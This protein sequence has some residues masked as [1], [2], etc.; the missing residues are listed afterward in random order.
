MHIWGGARVLAPECILLFIILYIIFP[1]LCKVCVCMHACMHVHIG[2]YQGAY[3]WGGSLRPNARR[4]CE[5]RCCN[6]KSDSIHLIHYNALVWWIIMIDTIIISEAPEGVGDRGA[7]EG[8]GSRETELANI[9]VHPSHRSES[10]IR[11]IDPSHRSE[12][13]IAKSSPSLIAKLHAVILLFY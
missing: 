7:S 1:V 6:G 9:R 2:S 10:P 12:S 4:R 8:D 3:I 5:T 11:V 13:S